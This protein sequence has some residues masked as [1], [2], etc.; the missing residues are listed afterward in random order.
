MVGGPFSLHL[1]QYRP[2]PIVEGDDFS[3]GTFCVVIE[4]SR[5]VRFDDPE[6]LSA[7]RS[8][9]VDSKSYNQILCPLSKQMPSN[10][11]PLNGWRVSSR[12]SDRIAQS[13]DLPAPVN[14]QK[15][16]SDVVGGLAR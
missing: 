6:L 7:P 10:T 2:T 15:L 3:I 16:A 12:S 4:G 13:E 8:V 5:V 11:R 1:D 9:G 14:E